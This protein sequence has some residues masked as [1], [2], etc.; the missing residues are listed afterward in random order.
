MAKLNLF[1]HTLVILCLGI[2]N[3]PAQEPEMIL[4]P[5]APFYAAPP[6]DP[7]TLPPPPQLEW[8]SLP[9]EDSAE[10]PVTAGTVPVPPPQAE[11][12]IAPPP[13]PEVETPFPGG[14][15]P[16][17]LELVRPEVEIW[18]GASEWP[19]IPPRRFNQLALAYIAGT[20]PV[21]LRVQFNSLAAGKSV[22]ARPGRGLTLQPSNGILTVSSS[23][24]CLVLAQLH[25]S[26]FQSHIIFYCEGVKTVL[27]ISRAPLAIVIQA[28]E[29]TGGGE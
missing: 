21:W 15:D 17:Q 19:Q 7:A 5:L 2:A 6:P 8:Q 26:V 23:G 4:P 1:R 28:E 3:L 12:L 25:E 11:A 18:R 10:E 29:E 24:E 22:S 13:P 20:E 9:P 27:P 16:A 14:P